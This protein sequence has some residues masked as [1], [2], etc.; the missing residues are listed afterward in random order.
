MGLGGLG[1]GGVRVKEIRSIGGESVPVVH[2]ADGRGWV[3]ALALRRTSWGGGCSVP[4][5]CRF[6]VRM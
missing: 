1:G 3:S 2:A 5:G 6:W 4:V